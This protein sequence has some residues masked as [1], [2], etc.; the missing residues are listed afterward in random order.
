[1]DQPLVSIL[2][3]N[4]NKA[5]FLAETLDS[6]IGQTYA[7]WE[8][9]VVDDHST[10]NSW[11]ILESYS[12]KEPRIKIFKR[13]EKRK[14]GG[15]AA[16]NFAFEMSNG[17]YIN[18]LD[19]DDIPDPEM[20]SRKIHLL[21]S[22]KID[23]VIGG[24]KKF[25]S[26]VTES[27]EFKELDY[28]HLDSDLALN[29]VRGVF[30]FQTAQPCFRRI[31]LERFNEL[32]DENLLKSQEAEFFT[33]ILLSKPQFKFES[34]STIYWR[35]S[36]GSKTVNYW[37]LSYSQKY[38]VS[39]QSYKKIYSNFLDYRRELDKP[40]ISFFK[41]VFNDMLLFLPAF[42]NEFWDLFIFGTRYNLFKG[43]FQGIKI[44][45]IRFLKTLKLI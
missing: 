39:Y 41:N 29:Y 18:W 25:N 11:E 37:G 15:N 30:W 21:E 7:H 24:V 14:R 3:P 22:E 6:V 2:I 31:F 43:R 28:D 38:L 1:M 9:I 5:S 8:C 40:V 10:D 35:I 16:R 20:L 26:S 36:E 17:E 42:S 27:E 23:F 19:S 12:R 33:R 13:P 34:K 45:G 32:F 44:L 4:Y